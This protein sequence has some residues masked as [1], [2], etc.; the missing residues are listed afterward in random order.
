MGVDINVS[1]GLKRGLKCVAFQGA[2]LS[3]GSLAAVAG[4]TSEPADAVLI[5]TGAQAATQGFSSAECLSGAALQEYKQVLGP[6]SGC[7]CIEVPLSSGSTADSV[8]AQ[9]D[10]GG[11][12]VSSLDVLPAGGKETAAQRLRLVAR[13]QKSPSKAQRFTP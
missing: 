8:Q 10:A 6:G 7:V 12:V 11:F 5:Y 1:A 2:A 9:L 4:A 3:P 13:P